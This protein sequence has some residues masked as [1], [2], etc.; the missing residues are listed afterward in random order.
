MNHVL[1]GWRIEN[2]LKKNLYCFKSGNFNS[3]KKVW[4]TD[5][6]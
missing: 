6:I 2:T 5:F 4:K 3:K 1:C